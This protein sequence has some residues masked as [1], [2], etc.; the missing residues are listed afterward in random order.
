MSLPK[1][2][3]ICAA[4]G[5]LALG[6]LFTTLTAHADDAL[7]GAWLF[8]ESEFTAP[9]PVE[10]SYAVERRAEITAQMAAGTFPEPVYQPRMYFFTAGHYSYNAINSNEERTLR[11]SLVTGRTNDGLMP[12]EQIRKEFGEIRMEAGT[13]WLEDNVIVMRP[14][15]DR[16]A[17]KMLAD[18]SNDI[19]IEY[20]VDGDTLYLTRYPGGGTSPANDIYRRAE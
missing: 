4:A 16:I 10:G 8:V 7:Q 1:Q 12:E 15:I 17:D 2:F 20:R 6:T 5:L 14:F 3:K 19:R 11:T 13:Y 9:P 18:G